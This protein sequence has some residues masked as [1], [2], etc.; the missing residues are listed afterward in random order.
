[1]AARMVSLSI[2]PRL[3]D[4]FLSERRGT[5]HYHLN[6]SGIRKDVLQGFGAQGTDFVHENER[7]PQFFGER[8]SHSELQY[9]LVPIGKVGVRNPVLGNH[10]R[11]HHVSVLLGLEEFYLEAQGFDGLVEF[12]RESELGL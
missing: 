10:E 7:D 1:M 4:I 9:G 12:F 5:G 11:F 3:L 8:L 2:L 6:V